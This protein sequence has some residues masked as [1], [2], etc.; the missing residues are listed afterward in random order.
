MRLKYHDHSHSQA[1]SCARRKISEQ[2]AKANSLRTWRMQEPCH[3]S[4]RNRAGLGRTFASEACVPRTHAGSLA[5]TARADKCRYFM[6]AGVPTRQA[7]RHG[8]CRPGAGTRLAWAAGAAAPTPA[9]GAGATRRLRALAKI[10]TRCGE[11]GSDRGQNLPAALKTRQRLG[12]FGGEQGL[13][14]L[15]GRPQVAGKLFRP[16]L[17]E[18]L[19]DRL[20]A[21]DGHTASGAFGPPAEV[22]GLDLVTLFPPLFGHKGAG[23]IHQHG[24]VFGIPAEDGFLFGSGQGFGHSGRIL[25]VFGGESQPVLTRK[26]P[27]EVDLTVGMGVNW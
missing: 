9:P 25:G 7:A 16:I 20:A 26:H 4:G 10:F 5:K 23:G 6:L 14:G 21:A 8:P 1:Q 11:V 18:L 27:Q 3:E 19:P 12:R 2:T 22:P 13:G 17:W 24:F 15:S